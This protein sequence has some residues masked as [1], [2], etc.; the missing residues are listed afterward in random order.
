MQPRYIAIYT[1]SPEHWIAPGIPARNLDADE[2]EQ[3]GIEA[4]TNAQC[5]ELV[6]VESLEALVEEPAPEV[7]E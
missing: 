3:Y 7:E 2:V 4:L 1:P 6:E 5:Y